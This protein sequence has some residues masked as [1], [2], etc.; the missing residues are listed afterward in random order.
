MKLQQN[1]YRS[2]IIILVSVSYYNEK[3]CL[4]KL[5]VEWR[6]IWKRNG[7]KSVNHNITFW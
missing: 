4:I 5:H 3:S 6:N 2:T 7:I 1:Q